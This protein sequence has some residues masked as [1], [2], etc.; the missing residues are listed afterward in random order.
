MLFHLTSCEIR[1]QTSSSIAVNLTPVIVV[2][3]SLE[4]FPASS[5]LTILDIN[6]SHIVDVQASSE[7]ASIPLPLSLI[8]F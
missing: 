4:V 2:S 7:E 1:E 8:P 6:G 3:L 5:E